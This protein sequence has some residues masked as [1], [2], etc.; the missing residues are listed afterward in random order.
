VVDIADTL[1][2]GVPYLRVLGP[3]YYLR[4]GLYLVLSGVAIKTDS[5]RFHAAFAVFATAYEVAYIGTSFYT[6]G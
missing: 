5:P 3:I 2:K 4:T 1:I 6:L